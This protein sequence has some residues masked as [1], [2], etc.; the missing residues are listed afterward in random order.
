MKAKITNRNAE[1]E[2]KQGS[3]LLEALAAQGYRLMSSCGGT[4]SCGM[5]RVKVL[6]GLKEPKAEY[7]GPLSEE[8][9]K[10]GWVLA[11]QLVVES[12]LT[13]QLDEKLVERWP[14]EGVEEVEAGAA[15]LSPLGVKLRRA[16]PGF[17]CGG[18]ICGY[19]SCALYAEALARGEA[20]PEAC[21]P[22]GELVRAALKRIIEAERERE[23]FI[24]GILEGVADKVELERKADRRIYL[25]TDRENLKE[26]AGRLILER[27]GRLATVSGV[28]KP[29]SGE[30]E[31]LYH[32]SFDRR[33]LVA[34]LRTILPRE[35]AKVKSVASFLPA[36]EYIEREIREL[37]GV[38]FAG[39]PRLERLIKAEDIPDDVYPLRK[40]FKLEDINGRRP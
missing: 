38:E 15:E 37:L 28:D 34:S 19:P 35:E 9:K 24:A 22:G 20:S 16:L 17:G 4:G 33:G 18:A 21:V 40:D 26:V 13:I 11:C 5:C 39:H 29:E 32:I 8:L 31:L 27:G 6:E 10:A 36:A 7:F 25:R 3:N 14:G 30:I 2:I 23:A 1:I 12:D